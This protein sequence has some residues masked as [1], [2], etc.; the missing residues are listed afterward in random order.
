V[1]SAVRII[2]LPAS[3]PAWDSA[4]AVLAQLR[5]ALDR[6]HLQALLVDTSGQGPRFIGA[7]A[8][9]GADGGGGVL[10]VAGYRVIANTSNGRK[11]YVDDLVTAAD[12]RQRGVGAA[13]LA[14]LVTR[15]RA[16]GCRVLDLD[17]GVQRFPAHRFYLGQGMA[18]TAHHFALDVQP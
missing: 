11:L 6:S 15:A 4:F 7:V 2:D 1:S 18:I 5:P 14:E 10:G 9:S 16:Q 17:S 3:S 12:H 13:L 8:T